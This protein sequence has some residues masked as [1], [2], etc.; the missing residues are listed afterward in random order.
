MK[1][2]APCIPN[3]NLKSP[4]QPD[5]HELGLVREVKLH[6]QVE[7]REKEGHMRGRID[8]QAGR[9][10]RE[11]Q[12]KVRPYKVE[13]KKER[14]RRTNSEGMGG[15]KGEDEETTRR[16]SS[17]S[18]SIEV[19]VTEAR[20]R[21]RAS[22]RLMEGLLSSSPDLDTAPTSPRRQSQPSSR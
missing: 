21:A 18:I 10:G 17:S 5:L 14:S 7:R 12:E 13:T 11:Q 1:S 6:R 8:W 20:V 3:H 15:G 16:S 22:L 4:F 2:G 9:K 19:Y